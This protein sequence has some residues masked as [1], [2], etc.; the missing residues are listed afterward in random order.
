MM[1]RLVTAP[2]AFFLLISLAGCSDKSSPRFR[3]ASSS[4]V[5]LVGHDPL[6]NRGMN[7]APAMFGDFLYIGNRSDSSTSCG[8]HDSRFD[9]GNP[10]LANCPH[11]YPG[12]LIVDAKDPARP[13]VVGQ[14]GPPYEGLTGISSRELRVWPAKALLM[15]MNFRCSS[16]LHVCPAGTDMDFTFDIKFY[17]LMDPLHP[18]FLSSYVPTSAAGKAVK[19]HE[20]YLWVDPAN[21]ER[22]LLF[23]STPTV[24]VDPTVPNLIV[25]DIS[26]VAAGGPVSAIAEGNWNQFFPGAEVMNSY[27]TN[28]IVHSVSVNLD[29]SRTYMALEAGHFLILDTT[30]LAAVPGPAVAGAPPAPP[31]SLA[32]KL[33]T[34]PTSRPTWGPPASVQASGPPAPC[35][36]AC[37]NSHSSV[38]VP[39]RPLI[40]NTD[41]VYGKATSMNSGC[42]WGWLRMLDI[43]DEGHPTV[44]GEYKLPENEM[45]FCGSAGDDP[46]TEQF[47]SF[48]SHN[49]TVLPHLA[50]LTWHAGGLQ[51]VDTTDPAHPRQVGSYLPAA[52]PSVANEDP[53]LGGGTGP[54]KVIFWSYPII[55][56]GLLY[57]VDVRNGLY[58]L[59]Y[60]GPGAS[61]ITNVKF[62][63]GN[64]NLGDAPTLGK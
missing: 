21:A 17:S 54:N 36:Q 55:K 58:I 19:P 51:I 1:S 41:E 22:A 42:P 12:V 27:D 20:M 14:L 43:S 40:V 47:A 28:L 62:L 63:E 38:K 15:V 59:R 6:F 10:T 7:A 9:P 23:I 5:Q 8:D 25:A 46:E 60:T 50:V 61:E 52:L 26:A 30:I 34:Q 45:S 35:T 29:A 2:F 57:V 24:S 64:S 32:D 56:D 33:L 11:P 13:K 48:T 49:P 37:P 53:R 3:P 16:M 4:N 18:K 39:G 31:L 44:V